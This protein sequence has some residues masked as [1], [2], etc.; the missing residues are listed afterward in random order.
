MAAQGRAQLTEQL[1]CP[2]ALL[3][4]GVPRGCSGSSCRDGPEDA[5]DQGL[6][7]RGVRLTAQEGH[8][9]RAETLSTSCGP[10]TR[11]LPTG[12]ARSTR[13]PRRKN[14]S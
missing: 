2:R 14:R 3:R 6:T 10:A 5:G 4:V 13:W 8:G 1:G 7:P 12:G 11:L 9:G